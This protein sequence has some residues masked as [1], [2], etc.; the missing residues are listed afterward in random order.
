MSNRH[1]HSV[2][3]APAAIVCWLAVAMPGAAQTVAPSG[4]PPAASP[5]AALTEDIIQARRK[6]V[7]DAAELDPAAR[8]KALE[9]YKQAGDQLRA[10]HDFRRKAAELEQERTTVPSRVADLRDKLGRTPRPVVLEDPTGAALP[11]LE[12]RLSQADEE[13]RQAQARLRELE[14]RRKHRADRQVQVP[15]QQ[16]AARERLAQIEAALSSQPPP[17]ERPELVL[18]HQT[19]LLAQQQ[20]L[21][22]ETA[23]LHQEL[24]TYEATVELLTLQI[25]EATVDAARKDDVARRWKQLVES[26][27]G[28]EAG[29]QAQNAQAHLEQLAGGGAPAAVVE[30]ARENVQLAE[31]RIGPHSLAERIRAI[32]A[33][34]ETIEARLKQLADERSNIEDKLQIPGIEDVIGTLLLNHRRDLRALIRRERDSE[35]RQEEI[36]N[37]RLAQLELAEQS[38][39]LANLDTLAAALV[40]GSPATLVPEEQH[41]LEEDVAKLLARRQQL[42]DALTTDYRTYFNRLVNLGARDKQLLADAREFLVLIDKH[43]LWIRSTAPVGE[44]HLLAAARA[45]RWLADPREWAHTGEVLAQSLLDDPAGL[46]L[47]VIVFGGVWWWRNR[48]MRRMQRHWR[49]TTPS[50]TTP[51]RQTCALLAV[52]LLVSAFYPAL[53][54]FLGWRRA[55]SP[56]SNEFARAAGAGLIAVS[57]PYFRLDALRRICR[58]RGLAEAHFRWRGERLRLIRRHL[59]WLIAIA[60]PTIFVAAMMENQTNEAYQTSLGR[61]VLMGGLIVLAVFLARVLRRVA[62]PAADGGGHAAAASAV[63]RWEWMRYVVAVAAPS[64]LMVLAGLGYFYTAQELTWRLI[65]TVWLTVGIVILHAMAVRWLHVARARLALERTRQAAESAA[66]AA[67]EDG[68]G[69]GRDD[70]SSSVVAEV[71]AG[72]LKET[73]TDLAAINQQTRRLLRI[74]TA[75]AVICGTWLVWSDVLPALGILNAPLWTSTEDVT[76]LVAHSDGVERPVTVSEP[77]VYTAA[78]LILALG[79]VI[80]AFIAAANVPGL[81][82]VAVLQHLPLDS[83]GR[84]AAATLA[85]Y[86]FYIAGVLLGF[87]LLGLGWSKMQWL[88]AALGIGLGFGLQEIFANFISGII[89]LFERP[90][91]VGDIVTVENVSGVVTRIQMRA[92]TVR[93]WDRREYIIPNKELITGRLLNWTL[94]DS[95]NRIVVNVGVAYGSDPDL[96]RALLLKVAH[97]SPHVTS[98]PKPAANFDGFGDSTLNFCL[99]AYVP[100]MDHYLDT[101]HGLH[102]AVQETFARHG[103]EIAFPQRDLRV[104]SIDREAVLHL[105]GDPAERGSGNGNGK[106][107]GSLAPSADTVLG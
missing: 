86:V 99:R 6:Q 24:P 92:T 89:L 79:V 82:E 21:Q 67:A 105:S 65:A 62:P 30:F 4:V 75:F 42:V 10:A 5:V 48:Q 94:S 57:F 20:A 53:M 18:A 52:K 27:R 76:R 40:E 93:N 69:T 46:C 17:G 60:L 31:R 103:I 41:E 15:E 39:E 80:A 61:L 68:D 9:H 22:A 71:A 28:L 34:A 32:D 19:L 96:V 23:F 29:Q 12:A 2:H 87:S 1:P 78:D 74:V 83:G 107:D 100:N 16:Q 3:I 37:V 102:T 59:R 11:Q 91:R 51:F 8:T 58:P 38:A 50:Y 104:R 56:L 13:L 97:E 36:A 90:I 101:V 7:E 43:V 98:D 63:S 14:A 55:A 66:A 88:V 49:E 70:E 77:R 64:M 45:L 26:R 44:K 54:W 25:R 73:A 106:H 95:V 33:E 35:S 72:D 85:R 84:Y 81:L 47:A